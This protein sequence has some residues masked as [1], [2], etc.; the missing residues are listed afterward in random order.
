MGLFDDMGIAFDMGEFLDAA[1]AADWDDPMSDA[2]WTR[3]V[4]RRPKAVCYERAEDF[5]RALTIDAATETFAYV[6]GGFVFGDFIEALV[7]QRRVSVRRMGMQMLSMNDENIDSLRNVVE[8]SGTERLD[9]CLSGY[10]YAT[11]MRKGGVVP[12]LF[13]QLDLEGLELHVAI[14]EVHCKVVTIETW[15]GHHLTMHGSANLRSSNSVEQ[16]HI[17]PDDGLYGFCD[18]VTQ[19]IVAAY[20]ILRQEKRQYK[21]RRLGGK[22]L[23]HA[24]RASGTGSPRGARE[25]GAVEA[26]SAAATASVRTGSASSAPAPRE[27]G[28]TSMARC[29]SSEG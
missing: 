11:E 26:P 23:W 22:R 29:R 28:T 12:Y 27:D 24:V 8:M 9:L 16:L 19:R 18:G 4:V 14:A 17:S 25:A 5:A 13:E 7:E 3:P 6:A 2:I 15:A 1:G 10:W 21:A 20:D